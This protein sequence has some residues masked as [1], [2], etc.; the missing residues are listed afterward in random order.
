MG[1]KE[2][3]LQ[4]FGSTITKNSPTILTGLAVAGLVS[5]TVMAVRTTPKAVLIMDMECDRRGD[6]S[7]LP[8]KDTIQLT[9]KCYIPTAIMGGLTVACI[10][11]ANSINLRRN[12][13][14]ASVYSLSEAA[15]KEYKTKVV[16]TI[17]EKK[18]KTIRDDIAKDR[19][20]KHPVNENEVFI[21]GNGETLCYDAITGRYFKSDIERIRK[22][23]N[24]VG[25]DMLSDMFVSLNDMYDY[26]GLPMVKI[27]DMVGWHVDDG[28]PEADFSSQ[29]TING[30]PCLVL[31]FTKDLR[32]GFQD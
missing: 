4:K 5:T 32:Y 1:T 9:W 24:K 16:E 19:I 10:I 23:V 15:L 3:V 18:E 13:A 28:F 29:L 7:A 6:V 20:T 11:Y 26:I 21:T 12:A 2:T 17:G 8:V 14:L 31:D 25:R 22:A 27:G 30:K